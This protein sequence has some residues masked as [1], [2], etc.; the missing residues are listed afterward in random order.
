M[1]YKV[2]DIMRI[3][4]GSCIRQ[5]P[6]ILDRFL[7][8]LDKLDK[9]IYFDYYFIDNNTDTESVKILKDWSKDKSVTLKYRKVD[10]NYSATEHT[11]N[12]SPKTVDDVISMKN[13]IIKYANDKKY[14]YIFLSDSDNEFHKDTLTH[15]ISRKK[16]VISEICWTKWHPDEEPLPNAWDSDQYTFKEDTI[17]RLNTDELIEV[18]GFGGMVLMSAKAIKTGLNYERIDNLNPKWGEDRFFSVRARILGLKL[19]IDTKYP[20]F[21]MYR[22]SEI[23]DGITRVMLAVPHTGNLRNELVRYLLKTCETVPDNIKVNFLLN[24]GMPTDSNRNHIV[25]QFLKSN[26]EWLFMIDSDIVPE[27][28]TLERLLAHNKKIIGALCF[29]TSS[30]GIPYPVIMKK[31]TDLGWGWTVDRNVKPLMRV[32]ATGASCIL[33]HRSILKQI[34]SP[35]RFG[36]DANGIVNVV[37]EDFDFCNKVLKLKESIYVDTTIQCLHYKNIDL[38]RF[39]DILSHVGDK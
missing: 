13:E 22:E 30:E 20:V 2:S 34:K 12:W 28:Q 15:L 25:Q 11:H 4:I 24:Y 14:D 27:R 36:Y 38:K 7:I 10:N 35:F 16:D 33:I 39:N 21:H 17:N 18:G 5:S 19:W 23:T 31:N 37:G 26:N 6:K 3:L 32:D 29:T 8:S 9:D 1:K